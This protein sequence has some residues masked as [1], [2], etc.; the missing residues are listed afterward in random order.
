MHVL[1]E[2]R[3]RC[4]RMDSHV[5]SSVC[6]AAGRHCYPCVC[7]MCP[8]CKHIM[9]AA[10]LHKDRHDRLTKHHSLLTHG[11][12]HL[13]P[14]VSFYLKGLASQLTSFSAFDLKTP[15]ILA[16]LCVR[17]LNYTHEKYFGLLSRGAWEDSS[18]FYSKNKLC[19]LLIVAAKCL[20]TSL[21]C[22][23]QW[24][25]VGCAF[26]R[27]HCSCLRTG[28]NPVETSADDSSCV[29]DTHH[30]RFIILRLACPRQIGLCIFS[31]SPIHIHGTRL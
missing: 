19:V 30:M 2:A 21:I 23:P 17:I 22:L 15:L 25:V 18:A 28:S 9:D 24:A 1:S 27:S 31:D 6:G 12:E 26:W 5:C 10:V 29:S 20:S 8:L 14:P 7:V 11:A 16:G 3:M 4:F 13:A